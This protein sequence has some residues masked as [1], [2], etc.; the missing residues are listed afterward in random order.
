MCEDKETGQA[1]VRSVWQSMQ[2][3]AYAQYNGF[4]CFYLSGG[5]IFIVHEDEDTGWSKVIS[6]HA[7]LVRMIRQ[8]KYT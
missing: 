6:F 2:I 7:I 4:D 8:Q 1:A 3:N 5:R